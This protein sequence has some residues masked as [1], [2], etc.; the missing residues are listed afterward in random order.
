MNYKKITPSLF[1]YDDRIYFG[2]ERKDVV[3]V[4]RDIL[5]IVGNLSIADVYSSQLQKEK[6]QIKKYPLLSF[7]MN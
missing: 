3:K 4:S 1:S 2:I 7:L 6:Q 5:G